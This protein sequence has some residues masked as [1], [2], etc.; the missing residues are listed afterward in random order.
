MGPSCM[1]RI[2]S[3]RLFVIFPSDPAGLIAEWDSS[4]MLAF[5]GPL[6]EAFLY[7]YPKRFAIASIPQY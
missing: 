1:F 6:V 4:S 7:M 2:A 5:S 3:E